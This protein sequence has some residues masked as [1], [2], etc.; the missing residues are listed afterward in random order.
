[1]DLQADSAAANLARKLATLSEAEA[2]MVYLSAVPLWLEPEIMVLLHGSREQARVVLQ[3]LEQL[4]IVTGVASNRAI[5]RP[6][7]RRSLL[8]AGWQGKLPDFVEV[9]RNLAD[10][11]FRQLAEAAD[12]SQRFRWAR[13]GMYHLLAAGDASGWEWLARLYDDAY[14]RGLAGTALEV[15]KPLGELRPLLS[16]NG[17]ATLAQYRAWTALLSGNLRQAECLFRAVLAYSQSPA[18]QGVIHRGLGQVL[19]ARQFWS[20]GLSH[21]QQSVRL[22]GQA[23]ETLGLALTWSRIGDLYQEM[24]DFNGGITPTTLPAANRPWSRQLYRFLYLPAHIYR[25]LGRRWQRLPFINVGFSYQNWITARFMLAAAAAY[26][27][28]ETTL[29]GVSSPQALYDVKVGRVRMFIQVGMLNRA[30][31]LIDELAAWEYVGDSEYRQAY[32]AYWRAELIRKRGQEKVAPAEMEAALHIFERY[33]Q[34][35]GAAAIYQRLGTFAAQAGDR[36]AAL[37]AFRQAA[38]YYD[39]TDQ[40]L[41]RTAVLNQMEQL[42]GEPL[43]DDDGRREYM[44][45]YASQL[46]GGYR[47]L[48]SLIFFVLITLL[49]F[50]ATFVPLALTESAL[51]RGMAG[52]LALALLL[53]W[54]IVAFW[55]FQVVYLGLGLF[56]SFGL[57]I[58]ILSRDPPLRILLD[59]G[60]LTMAGGKRDSPLSVQWAAISAVQS[61]DYCI[62]R[63]AIDLISYVELV[64]RERRLRIPALA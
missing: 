1:M 55:V 23:G 51:L 7:I 3:S 62:S 35:R 37:A 39:E 9:N 47:W 45:R 11:C 25:Q 52:G 63:H 60:G 58:H 54:P 12:A 27:Q 48:I 18:L 24:A 13:A 15:I 29:A 31:E 26:R 36:E 43:P 33:Q 21:L 40:S 30:E 5:I 56:I 49:T 59:P 57:P 10:Y 44:V 16:P 50:A 14:V 22:L 2:R 20:E 28:A 8:R 42:A 6:E 61:V 38:R 64:G 46:A 4:L 53:A 19:T 17:R 32:V 34:R 41:R